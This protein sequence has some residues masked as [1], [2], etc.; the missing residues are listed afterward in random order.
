MSSNKN[1]NN[2]PEEEKRDKEREEMGRELTDRA[3]RDGMYDSNQS[4]AFLKDYFAQIN[5][6]YQGLIN[7]K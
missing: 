1:T 4:Y 5:E 2:K 3:V 6:D 7:D